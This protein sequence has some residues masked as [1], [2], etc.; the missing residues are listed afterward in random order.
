MSRNWAFCARWLVPKW[1]PLTETELAGSSVA[2]RLPANPITLCNG[3]GVFI[4]AASGQIRMAADNGRRAREVVH[5][6]GPSSLAARGARGRPLVAC[7]GGRHDGCSGCAGGKPLWAAG[8][9]NH[10][11]RKRLLGRMRRIMRHA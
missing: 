9:R 11:P 10:R 3:H 7:G 4:V 6:H 1:R 2:V 8:C 5:G